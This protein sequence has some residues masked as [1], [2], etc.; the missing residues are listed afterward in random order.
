MRKKSKDTERWL[1]IPDT[2]APYHDARAWALITEQ[3]L[4]E[5]E[6]DGVCVL[7]DFYDCYAISDYRK[8]PRRERSL[9]SELVAARRVRKPLD[10]YPFKRRIFVKG[11]HEWR[12]ERYLEERAPALYEEVM[13]RDLL[14][15]AGWEVI[16]Y[17][18][19][20]QIGK[21][22]VTHDIGYAGVTSTRK[23]MLDYQDN[24]VIG[25][26]HILQYHV[27]GNAKGVNHVGASFGWLG[28]TKKVDYKHQMKARKEWV[29]GFGI[30]ALRNNGY[31]YLK[32]VPILHDYS[33]EVDGR[34][35]IQPL[36]KGL[37]A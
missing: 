16:E 15:L 36:E 23:T 1:F 34:I 25:H 37:A 28:D 8:D 5:I 9:K 31:M 26:N 3:V 24:V 22:N 11:N 10:E 18:N 2:H 29:L 14:G 21:L 30:G 27:E 7:G 32:P 13:E 35:F 6:F 19:D 20:A 33:C 17:M 12:L 4:E